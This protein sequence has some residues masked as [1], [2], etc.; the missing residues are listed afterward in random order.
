MTKFKSCPGLDHLNRKKSTWA[1]THTW[2]LNLV[3]C[4]WS[5]HVSGHVNSY[6]PGQKLVRTLSQSR[7]FRPEP[8]ISLLTKDQQRWVDV[9]SLCFQ[10]RPLFLFAQSSLQNGKSCQRFSLNSLCSFHSRGTGN[11]KIRG[12][13]QQKGPS[14][15]I[16]EY[17]RMNA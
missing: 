9:L 16:T 13:R 15:G 2:P 7:S 12:W 6:E 8:A 4:V 1:L 5:A 14:E 11:V 17:T 3:V 10:H